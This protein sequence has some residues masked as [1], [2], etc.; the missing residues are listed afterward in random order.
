MGNKIGNVMGT[1][2]ELDENTLGTRENEK[3]KK[4]FSPP[5][6]TPPQTQ[7]EKKIEAS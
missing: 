6:L 5:S 2:L 3:K 1:H 4:S 7:K